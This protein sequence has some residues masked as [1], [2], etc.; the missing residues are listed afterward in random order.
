MSQNSCREKVVTN[1]IGPGPCSSRGLCTVHRERHLLSS[2]AGV[3]RNALCLE[4]SFVKQILASEEL[5]RTDSWQLGHVRARAAAQ[6]FGLY[7]T[8][9][10]VNSCRLLVSRWSFDYNA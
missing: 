1:L 9:S 10:L 4:M 2:V 6:A 5:G 8:A 7:T 3:C